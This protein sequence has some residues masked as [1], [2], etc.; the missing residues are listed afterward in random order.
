M[1]WDQVCNGFACKFNAND[2][3]IP[4]YVFFALLEQ[5]NISLCLVGAKA[6]GQKTVCDMETCQV[7]NSAAATFGLKVNRIQIRCNIVIDQ[8]ES[9]NLIKI[10]QCFQVTRGSRM[11]NFMAAMKAAFIRVG[12]ERL[13]ADA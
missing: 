4:V 10:V 13:G 7:T 2:K 9:H 12:G 8:L 1:K 5:T 3:Q 11:T 6:P